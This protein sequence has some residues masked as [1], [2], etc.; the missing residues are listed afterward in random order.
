MMLIS[1][2][3]I[4]M[5]VKKKIV[6]KRNLTDKVA[7]SLGLHIHDR[8][9]AYPPPPVQGLGPGLV[10]G[11]LPV[12]SQGLVP[13]PENVQDLVGREQ[14]PAPGPTGVLLPYE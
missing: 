4:L 7:Q 10:A 13:I 14:D 12:R 8:H 11:V 3:I 6:I 5:P 2:N 9:H 1:Q